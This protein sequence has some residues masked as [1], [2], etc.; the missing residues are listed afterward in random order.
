L[1][2]IAG[3][4]GFPRYSLVFTSDSRTLVVQTMEDLQW[5]DA[6]TGTLRQSWCEHE[7]PETEAWKRDRMLAYE[8]LVFP[9][10]HNNRG[11]VMQQL[12]RWLPD[13]WAHDDGDT[14]RVFE[15][16]G[17]ARLFELDEPRI[18]SATLSYDGEILITVHWTDSPEQ[19]LRCW[20]VPARKP[21][22]LVLVCRSP[23][24]YWCRCSLRLAPDAAT[25]TSSAAL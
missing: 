8:R 25:T 12:D 13:N 11:W 18:H 15:A 1:E 16:R 24:A 19:L 3:G 4:I 5:R 20:D 17:G 2:I 14:V 7:V 23:S 10:F 9:G 6:A 21:L 22:R